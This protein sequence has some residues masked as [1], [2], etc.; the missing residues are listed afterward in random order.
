MN[1]LTDTDPMPFG[2]Y[3]PSNESKLMQ[4]VPVSYLHYL[5]DHCKFKSFAN[6]EAP[7][8][9]KN[10]HIKNSWRVAQYIKNSLDAL[11]QEDE[12]RIW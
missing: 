8:E 3:G 11:K 12:D 9:D 4:D 10:E 5:W 2:K 7:S 1:P 6:N